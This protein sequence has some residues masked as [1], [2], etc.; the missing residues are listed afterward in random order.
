MNKDIGVRMEL[1]DQLGR[2]VQQV[3]L[4]L[5]EDQH[6]ITAPHMDLTPTPPTMPAIEMSKNE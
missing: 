4:V 1:K 2:K 5:R 6:H 3:S